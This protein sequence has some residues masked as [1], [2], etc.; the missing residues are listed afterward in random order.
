LFKKV[1]V[2][3]VELF[4]QRYAGLA[5]VQIVSDEGNDV[6]TVSMISL[7]DGWFGKGQYSCGGKNQ[8]AIV[9]IHVGT[10]RRE[11][12]RPAG[13]EGIIS[14]WGPMR[15]TDSLDLRV[16]D[17]VQALARTSA[18]EFGHTLGLVGDSRGKE[19][20]WMDGCD[21]G[22]D[23]DVFDLRSPLLAHRFENGWHIM[24]PGAKKLNNA[25][26]GEPNSTMRSTKR[27][28]PIFGIFDS[29][30]LQLVHPP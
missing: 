27:R 26:I 30:Y 7:D 2:R 14:S 21:E 16:E 11:M 19:C 13:R 8:K 23:C 17:A 10:F 22:H 5:D 24:D 6:S 29:S 3:T 15:R 25:R 4:K 28:E 1:R 20:Q 12:T 9:R 18:H